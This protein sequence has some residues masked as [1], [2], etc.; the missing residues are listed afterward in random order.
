VLD[1]LRQPLEAGRIILNR[2]NG[3][4]SYPAQFLLVLAANPCPC[5]AGGQS[6]DE[7]QCVCPPGLRSRYKSRLSGPL[8]DRIDIFVELERV[9]R[10]VLAE[11]GEGEPSALV[12]ARVE[13]AR[14]R[15]RERLAGTSWTVNGDVPGPALRRRWPIAARVLRPIGLAADQGRL[16]T[17]GIDR[18]LRVA[19]TLADLAGLDRPGVEQVEEAL[20]LR[21]G[22]KT[23]R[24][25]AVP[26]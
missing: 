10:R 14:A 6:V 18:A 24:P 23:P 3:A 15:A 19:W 11:H 8:R 26:A 21:L 7:R 1:A 20:E 9:S 2:A 12:R 22:N 17:R 4:A 5:S 13:A 16:S 25:V